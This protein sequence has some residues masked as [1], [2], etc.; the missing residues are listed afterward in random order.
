MSRFTEV[1]SVQAPNSIGILEDVVVKFP[2]TILEG[3]IEDAGVARGQD[4]VDNAGLMS[5]GRVEE[6]KFCHTIKSG[7]GE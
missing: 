5:D 6:E 7:I 1:M 3:G 2:E 4:G